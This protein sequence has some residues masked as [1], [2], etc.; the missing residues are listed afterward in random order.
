MGDLR[1]GHR[2]EG[3]SHSSTADIITKPI[4]FFFQEPIKQKNN[5]NA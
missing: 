2:G 1:R 3:T 4:L 5:Q